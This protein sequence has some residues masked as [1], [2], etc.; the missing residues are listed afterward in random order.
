MRKRYE[1]ALAVLY[2]VRVDSHEQRLEARR[3]PTEQVTRSSPQEMRSLPFTATP[4]HY[5]VTW[6][7]I[8]RVYRQIQI[9]TAIFAPNADRPSQTHLWDH[10]SHSPRH[11][12]YGTPLA[13]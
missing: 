13:P 9:Q 5:A 10:T 12:I 7:L 6:M 11:S 2:R 8:F 4:S 3:P 1:K